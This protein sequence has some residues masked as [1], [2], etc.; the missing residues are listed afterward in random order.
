MAEETQLSQADPNSAAPAVAPQTAAVTTPPA[1]DAENVE[2]LPSWAQR[3]IS[4][5]RKEAASHRK[6]KTEAERTAQAAA[7]QAAK[8]QGRWQELAEQYEPAAK[9]ATELEAFVTEL[10][11]RETA[12]VPDK[13]KK[14]I[15]TGDALT[16]LRWVQEAK[17]AGILSAPPA[18]QTDAAE[19]GSTA[20]AKSEEQRKEL[21]AIYGV[22]PRFI[23]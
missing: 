1:L 15:P 18:P 12:G 13:F 19:R 17:A 9:R 8:E 7:E 16:T 4:D 14:L 20:S 6:A 10:L 22:D 23:E 3:T 11:E 2:A 5:L 21:A